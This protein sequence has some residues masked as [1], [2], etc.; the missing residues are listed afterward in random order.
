MSC[1]RGF[2]FYD[3]SKR[4][5]G[6]EAAVQYLYQLDIHGDLRL[7]LSEDFWKLRDASAAVKAFAE[8]LIA[9]VIEHRVEVDER[10]GKVLQNFSFE[11]LNVVDRNVLRL[12]VYEMFHNLDVPPVVAINEGIELA[13]AFGGEDSG[14]FVNGL[15]DKIKLDVTRSLRDAP[16]NKKTW[17]PRPQSRPVLPK[18]TEEAQH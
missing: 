18:P 5:E 9:G 4:R 12:A 1:G 8:S 14:K 2:N 7:D 15:L 10:I 6:R 3:M 13:K 17:Q 16:G 11:R